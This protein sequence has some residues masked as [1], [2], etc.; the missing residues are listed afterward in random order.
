MD[1]IKNLLIGGLMFSLIISLCFGFF[2]NQVE[3]YGGSTDLDLD[4]YIIKDTIDS[5]VDSYKSQVST[6]NWILDFVSEIFT[7]VLDFALS[8]WNSLWVVGAVSASLENI[9]NLPGIIGA[10]LI[11]IGGIIILFEVYKA[12]RGTG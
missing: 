6:G 5:D 7:G 3:S 10:T 9:L 11:S 8:I 12:V 2:S 4:S 1:N